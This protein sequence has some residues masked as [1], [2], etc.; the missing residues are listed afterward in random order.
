MGNLIKDIEVTGSSVTQVDLTGL[1]IQKGELYEMVF[2]LAK[3]ASGVAVI[4]LYANDNT[5][6]TNY[7]L[8]TL[9]VNGTNIGAHRFNSNGIIVGQTTKGSYSKTYVKLTNDGHIVFL[10]KDIRYH[11]STAPEI[12]LNYLTSAFTASSITKINLKSQIA[13]GIGVGSRIQLYKVAEKVDEVIVAGSSVTQ[14]DFTGLDIGKD[15]E[16]MLV[17]DWTKPS[18]GSANLRIYINDNTTSTNYYLQGLLALSTTV[19]GFRGNHSELV[20]IDNT[21]PNAFSIAKLKL[22][23]SGYFNVQVDNIENMTSSGSDIYIMKKRIS[24]T[25][26]ISSITKLS[27]VASVASYISIGSRFELYKLI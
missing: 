7:H 10:N 24:S 15:N 6:N 25:F 20:G 23:N 9:G 4:G 17:S 11:D 19:A 12:V 2:T 1:D 26:T 13:N 16:Y 8:Q 5:T 22:A 21:R 14:V 27:I 3:N 18:S